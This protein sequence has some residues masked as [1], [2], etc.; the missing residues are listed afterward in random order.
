VEVDVAVAQREQ[1]ALP[2]PGERSELDEVAIRSNGIR[3]EFLDLV[4]VEEAHLR[5]LA[6]RRLHAEDALVDDVP[7]LLRAREQLL[8]HTERELRLPRRAAR[9]RGDVVLDRGRVDLVERDTCE[10]VEVRQ[11]LADA[12]ER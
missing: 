4:P 11:D 9:Q 8:E 3:R 7:A 6:P 12:R 1:L 2:Q 5:L 10:D